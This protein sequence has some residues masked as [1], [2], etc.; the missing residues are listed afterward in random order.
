MRVV[1][2]C[3]AC[4]AACGFHSAAA[5]VD[6]TTADSPITVI[7][8]P[9]I[10]ASPIEPDAAPLAR[11]SDGLIGLWTF[12]EAPG[13]AVTTTAADTSATGRPVP[14]KVSFGTVTYAD[15]NVTPDGVAVLASDPLPHL[16]ADVKRSAGVTLEAWVITSTDDQGTPAAPV[17]VA[18][19]DA[20]VVSR[21]ISILQVG[22]RWV[23]RVRTTADKNGGPDL[24]SATDVVANQLTHLVV[25][26]DAAQ[27]ILYVDGEVSFA[28]PV[29]GAPLGWDPAYRLVLGNELVR[30]RQWAGSFAL[31]AMYQDALSKL[32]VDRNFT[33]GPD[34]P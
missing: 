33:V 8:A 14:L 30:G 11:V 19:L 3:L 9:P 20:S 29:P 1:L 15:G 13:I 32:Q 27:R 31:V 5:P 24:V 34:S 4:T 16:N 26:A 12:S 10:D 25:V 23:A 22:K 2:A 28:D 18:G 21:N 6:A 17:V 7:D